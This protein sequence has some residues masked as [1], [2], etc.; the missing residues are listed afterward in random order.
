MIAAVI[1]ISQ[2][3]VPYWAML[4]FL[5]DEGLAYL[6]IFIQMWKLQKLFS[7]RPCEVQSVVWVYQL[8]EEP[9]LLKKY[10]F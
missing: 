10:H 2:D 3:S 1:M 8:N 4:M 5:Q 9:K 6:Q 7:K